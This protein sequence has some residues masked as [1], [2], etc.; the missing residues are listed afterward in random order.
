M[1]IKNIT[2]FHYLRLVST[3]SIFYAIK[4]YIKYVYSLSKVLIFIF[5]ICN[6]C[7]TF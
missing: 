5:I 1:K 3:K 2:Y 7:L 4:K 6:E